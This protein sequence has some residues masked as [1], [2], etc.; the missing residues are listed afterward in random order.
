MANLRKAKY[1]ET[2]ASTKPVEATPLVVIYHRVSSKKQKD[3]M[4][5]DRQRSVTQAIFERQFSDGLLIATV[6]DEAY[7]FE[8]FEAERGFWA[9]L[10]PL[11]AAGECNT[12]LVSGDDR[13]FRGASSELRGR[14]T[15]LFRRHGIRLV[16][17]GGTT[18]YDPKQTSTRLVTSITQELGAIAKLETVKTMYSGRRRRLVEDNEWRL[19][20]YPFGYRLQVVSGRRKSYAYEIVEDEA[21]IIRD[22]YRLYTG[23]GGTEVLPAASGKL[24]STKIAALLNQHGLT[25]AGWRASV[26]K[27]IQDQ[28][29]DEWDTQAVLRVLG[30]ETY[31]GKLT[32]V[33][34]PTEKVPGFGDE[35][36]VKRLAVPAIVPVELFEA[37]A[38]VR[39]QRRYH[40]LDDRESRLDANWLHGL[41]ACPACGTRMIGV[42]ASNKM[43][44]YKCPE[45]TASDSHGMLRADD[46]EGMLTVEVGRVLESQLDVRRLS[47]AWDRSAGELAGS[48]EQEERQKQQLERMLADLNAQLKKLTESF[49]KGVIEESMYI[50]L[51]DDLGKKIAEAR[52]GLSNLAATSSESR[53]GG[54]TL[55]TAQRAYQAAMNDTEARSRIL[56]IFCRHAVDEIRVEKLESLDLAAMT[57][58]DLKS[59]YQAGRITAKAV[60]DHLGWRPKKLITAWG[61]SGR[62]SAV[63]YRLVV[64]WKG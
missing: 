47:R 3:E 12:I 55:I 24:G 54:G 30:N 53:E 52:L 58:D 62:K 6:E 48:A 26:P 60:R 19:S 61:K 1:L 31:T 7:N 33:F 8:A 51:K 28:T 22:I 14:V 23:Q 57:L 64:S 41:I 25:R 10:V 13:I 21:R 4:T 38:A 42:L 37:A 11:V 34:Q 35:A 15:D 39:E 20:V 56:K 43:R 5:I 27:G 17:P 49:I 32:V 2:R 45:S 40:L 44:Y 59:A 29:N 36:A 46:A 9:Q 50:E 16:T 63:D 18:H